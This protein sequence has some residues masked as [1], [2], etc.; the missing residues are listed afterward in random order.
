MPAILASNLIQSKLPQGPQGIQG[1]QGAQGTQG[2]VG[3]QGIQGGNTMI[4]NIDGGMPNS[5]YGG[6]N[7]FDAGGII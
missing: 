7:T 3:I 4:L 2:T 6:I 5:I 1:I